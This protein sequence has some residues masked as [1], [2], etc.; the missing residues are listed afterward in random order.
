MLLKSGKYITRRYLGEPLVIRIFVKS[1]LKPGSPGGIGKLLNNLINSSNHNYDIH[2]LIIK[3]E[4]STSNA[5]N[6]YLLRMIFNFINDLATS[7]KMAC[8]AHTDAIMYVGSIPHLSIIAAKLCSKPVILY[9]NGYVHHELINR[10]RTS[11]KL[12]ISLKE[13][14]RFIW[15][16]TLFGIGNLFVDVYVF[17]CYGTYE[18][19][20]IPRNKNYKIIPLWFSE[21]EIDRII[22][23]QNLLG[24]EKENNKMYGENKKI[25]ITYTSNVYSP[26]ILSS[27]HL[28]KLGQLIKSRS[29]QEFDFL[30]ID[31]KSKPQQ[32]SNY[33][34]VMS[35]LSREEYFKLLAKSFLYIDSVIDDELR[36]STLEA[37]LLGVPVAKITH[38]RYWDKLD[39]KY[40]LF[41][42]S[43]REFIERVAWYIDHA[44][45][46][47]PMYSSKVR[48]YVLSKRRWNNVR[49]YFLEIFEL[50]GGKH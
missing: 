39:F 11:S 41:S 37:M 44:E 29:K 45:E 32:V 26:K 21:Q 15:A 38:P 31:P 17:P 40:E 20:K 10:V 27:Q 47:Y 12:Y 7:S 28:I 1:R 2:F 30:I 19:S 9:V 36:Y 22:S 13:I 18:N 50:I 16:E 5:V 49:N 14:L 34:K 3:S 23:K 8:E 43:V 46:L 42:T 6:I 24:G 33:I 25:I 48:E 4:Y 35:R